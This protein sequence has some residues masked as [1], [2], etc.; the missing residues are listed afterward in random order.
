MIFNK[1]ILE[2]KLKLLLIGLD[3]STNNTQNVAEFNLISVCI[4][5]SHIY[6][7]NIIYTYH[8][9]FINNV[10]LK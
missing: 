4:L 2:K 5:K 10:S 3:I 8:L 9:G 7:N 1:N 6:Q